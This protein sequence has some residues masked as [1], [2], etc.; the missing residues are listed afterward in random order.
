MGQ[1]A[2]Q[3]LEVQ[4]AGPDAAVMLGRWRLTDTPQA[5]SGVFSIVF[6]RRPEGWRVIHDHT[7]SDPP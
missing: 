5:G 2:F 4:P 7:S 1:L 3:V 6:E